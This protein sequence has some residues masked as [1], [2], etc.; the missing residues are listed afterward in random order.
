[1]FE[2]YRL[3]EDGEAISALLNIAAS[4]A[5]GIGVA[6]LGRHVGASL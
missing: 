3:T 6:L 2:S 5:V 1:M 4:L